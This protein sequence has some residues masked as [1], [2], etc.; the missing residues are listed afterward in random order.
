MWFFIW[1]IIAL[2]I[3]GFFAWSTFAIFKQKSTL[4]KFAEKNDLTYEPGKILDTAVVTGRLQ[5]M[6]FNLFSGTE[7]TEDVRGQRYMSIIEFELGSGMRVNGVLGTP[8]MKMFID[9]L[10]YTDTIKLDE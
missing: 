7:P 1:L 9:T 4:K 10:N 6:R 2:F 3:L 5:G 8:E